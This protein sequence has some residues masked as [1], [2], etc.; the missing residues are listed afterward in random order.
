[1]Y[2]TDLTW[3]TFEKITYAG[4][5]QIFYFKQVEAADYVKNSEILKVL[6]IEQEVKDSEQ[7]SKVV[8]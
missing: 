2:N 8:S 7:A 6:G 4:G 5:E 1:M 3:L